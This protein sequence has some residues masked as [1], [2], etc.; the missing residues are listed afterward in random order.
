M[1]VGQKIDTLIEN[2]KS[3]VIM[4]HSSPD[5][6]ALCSC[7][8]LQDLIKKRF[9]KKRVD[10]AIEGK[11]GEVLK[12]I[13]KKTKLS[14][15]WSTWF[16]YDLAICLDCPTFKRLGKHERTFK[17]ARNKI[18]IDHHDTN[19]EFGDVNKVD[20]EASST[21]EIIYKMFKSHDVEISPRIAKLI[22][23]GIVTDT[24]CFTANNIS[25]NTHKIVAE[26]VK[27]GINV[28]E[29]KNYF[30]KNNSKNKTALLEKALRSLKYYHNDEIVL[31]KIT[32]NDLKKTE[33]KFEDT[34]GLVD[35]AVNIS[36]VDIAIAIIEKK[37]KNYYISLRSKNSNVSE[38]A[39][40]MGGGGHTNMAA[41][42][43][44]GDLRNMQM[45][46]IRE[47]EKVCVTSKPFDKIFD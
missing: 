47:C 26:I 40:I 37:A 8:A 15:P 6:D 41:F 10:I 16:R 38:V 39:K 19:L 13:V 31:M 46:L 7:I 29:I 4:A 1:T 30:F 27:S 36:C 9:N 24:A 11:V 25:Q 44:T 45:K 22:Y 23:S 18:N 35:N 21:C 20:A 2:A 3:I 5:A 28:D 32:L 34:V 42:Q 17:L 33:T 12:P 14:P 43:H